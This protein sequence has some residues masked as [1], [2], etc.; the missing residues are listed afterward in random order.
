MASKIEEMLRVEVGKVEFD[1]EA[2]L[3]VF[4]K[5][6]NFSCSTKLNE[7][8]GNSYVFMPGVASDKPKGPEHE[9]PIGRKKE[10]QVYTRE[11]VSTKMDKDTMESFYE[12]TLVR[13]KGAAVRDPISFI[14][15]VD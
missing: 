10:G 3:E 7:Y 5:L 15:A 14:K 11:A 9:I 6:V 1:L 12:A 4:R 8:M 2:P 13:E